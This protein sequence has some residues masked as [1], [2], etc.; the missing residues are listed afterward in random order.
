MAGSGWAHTVRMVAATI[1]AAAW[2]T[3]P[4]A[5]RTKWTRQRCQLAPWSTAAI[6][7]FKPWWASLMTTWTPAR[8]L[9]TRLRRNWCQTAPSSL[10]PTSSPSTSRSPLERTPIATTTAT[11]TTRPPSRTCTN[12][13][14]NQTYG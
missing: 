13:A 4:R 3:R 11:A 8:P 12:L 6:E 7:L 14:S 2:G 5:F 10:G 9:A 1:S